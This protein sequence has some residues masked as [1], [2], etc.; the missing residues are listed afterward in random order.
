M[1]KFDRR[2]VLLIVLLLLLFIGIVLMILFCPLQR[3]LPKAPHRN[4]TTTPERQLTKA[5]ERQLTTTRER[6]LTKEPERQPT[7]TPQIQLPTTCS[8]KFKLMNRVVDG[9]ANI[10]MPVD[11]SL[12]C[13]W[14]CQRYPNCTGFIR[15]LNNDTCHYSTNRSEALSNTTSPTLY[16]RVT[17]RCPIL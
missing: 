12:S 8:P 17:N 1:S 3:Q 10:P 14:W 16:H 2:C 6:Q 4:V 7:T 15:F 9:F 11:A 13:R 5:P